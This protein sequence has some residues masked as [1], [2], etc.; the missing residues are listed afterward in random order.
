FEAIRPIGFKTD[1]LRNAGSLAYLVK[2]QGNTQFGGMAIANLDLLEV[3]HHDT[4]V[5]V[6]QHAG[7]PLGRH[8]VQVTW[9]PALACR[10]WTVRPR[11]FDNSHFFIVIP[12]G[13]IRAA[14]LQPSH[15]TLLISR[16]WR[17]LATTGVSTT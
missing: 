1:I 9:K 5:T 12:E 7:Q 17:T 16:D 3:V 6:L 4:G 10:I 15:M 11:I 13:E 2:R 8:F 14:G